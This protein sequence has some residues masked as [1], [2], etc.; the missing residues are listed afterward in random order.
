MAAGSA[1][2]PARGRRRAGRAVFWV[3]FGLSG[4][5]FLGGI[6]VM[7]A[8]VRLYTIPS[9]SMENTLRPGDHI[10]VSTGAA[11]LRRGD[12]IL[13]R[14]PAA[15]GS[16]LY[17]MRLIGLPGDHV[18]CCNAQGRITVNG[19]ALDETY[20]YPGD[21]PSTARFSVTLGKGQIWVL[22]D[23]RSISADSRFW[24]PPVL[25]S[26][27]AGRVFAVG[28][29]LKF[30]TLRTPETFIAD[31]LAP[32]DHRSGFGS[33]LLLLVGL[34]GIVLLTAIGITRA[35]ARRARR[36]RRRRHDDSLASARP[37][38]PSQR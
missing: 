26:D 14:R 4:V 3:L 1:G 6:V 10:L 33:P 28:T 17:A 34:A 32:P 8:S 31:G 19:R 5:L 12:V 21:A 36:R 15:S 24:A 16:L 11:D 25:L 29:G 18:A 30:S 35:V 37:P 20:L 23:H 2:A 22:G 13:F 27:V 7:F 9:T 38:L